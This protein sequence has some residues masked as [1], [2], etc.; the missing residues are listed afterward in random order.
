M[1]KKV[2]LATEDLKVVTGGSYEIS[3]FSCNC[4]EK[5]RE[6]VGRNGEGTRMIYMCMNCNKMFWIDN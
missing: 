6:S 1:D 4:D 2:K 5:Y 3:D